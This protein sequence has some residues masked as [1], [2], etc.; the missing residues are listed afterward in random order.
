[1][2]SHAIYQ[3]LIVGGMFGCIVWIVVAWL[4]EIFN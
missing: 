4:T 1:M 3:L 2:T